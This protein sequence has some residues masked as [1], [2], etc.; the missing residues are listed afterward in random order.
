GPRSLTVTNPDGQTDTGLDVFAVLDFAPAIG[1]VSPVALDQGDSGKAFTVLG[2]NFQSGAKIAFVTSGGITVGPVTF[3]NSGQLN[4][5]LSIAA[6]APLGAR[7][8]IV[9]DPD[10]QSATLSNA[11][12]VRLP[13]PKI[14][15]ITPNSGGQGQNIPG[16][17]IAGSNFQPSPSL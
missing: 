5:T 10:I 12:T 8:V 16:V 3:V 6:N 13:A 7:T 11:F 14:T 15:S 4:T 1:S 17:L 9:T 2:S